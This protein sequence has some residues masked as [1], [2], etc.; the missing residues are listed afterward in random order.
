MVALAGALA[1][2]S[3]EPRQIRKEAAVT[4][5]TGAEMLLVSTTSKL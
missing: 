1:A 5:D 3:C 4:T 2:L